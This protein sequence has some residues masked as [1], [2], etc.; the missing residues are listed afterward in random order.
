MAKF[1]SVDAYIA[2]FPPDVRLKIESV[3]QA[4]RRAVPGS[5]E[6]ISYDIAAFRLH[7]RGYLGLAGWKRHISI[8]PIPRA[9]EEL[10][11]ELTAHKSGK[12]TLQFPLSKPI[13]LG[14]VGKVA[15]LLAAQRA[16]SSRADADRSAPIG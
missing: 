14:L 11:R 12:G 10:D 9:D 2:S 13:P 8:Y 1:E 7:G 6:A 3:R 4:I 15:A 5:E 16:G